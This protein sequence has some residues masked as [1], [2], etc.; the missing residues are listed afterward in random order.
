MGIIGS[1]LLTWDFQIPALGDMIPPNFPPLFKSDSNNLYLRSSIDNRCLSTYEAYPLADVPWTKILKRISDSG[2]SKNQ[3]PLTLELLCPATVHHLRFIDDLNISL[4]QYGTVYSQSSTTIQTS[5]ESWNMLKQITLSIPRSSG[6]TAWKSAQKIDSGVY[7]LVGRVHLPS[8]NLNSYHVGLKITSNDL[9]LLWAD[10]IEDGDSA[11]T[12]GNVW[13]GRF[14]ADKS[15]LA[16]IKHW[17]KDA[18][19]WKSKLELWTFESNTWDAPTR[20]KT[21]WPSDFK[22]PP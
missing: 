10:E 6:Q 2:Q 7:S 3:H 17:Y 18:S 9:E 21:G 5:V 13:Y 22:L 4:A 14:D 19:P 16:M 1:G 8:K 20:K 15:T 12:N 11:W